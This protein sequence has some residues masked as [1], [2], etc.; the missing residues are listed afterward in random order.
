MTVPDPAAWPDGSR[1]PAC[2]APLERVHRHLLDRWISVFRSVH[3]YRCTAAACGWEGVLGRDAAG[4][5]PPRRWPV[6]VL[7]FVAGAALA[8]VAAQGLRQAL[9]T[10]PANDRSQ[11]ALGQGVETQSRA[12]A[13]GIDFAGA[14]L[15]AT[16]PRVRNNPSPLQLR[17]SCA[18]GVPGANPYRGTVTQALA[19]ARLPREVVRQIADMAER[20]AVLD[21]VQITRLG[22]R[23][24]NGQR[25]YGSRITAMAFGDTLCFNTRVNFPDGHVEHAAL[26]EAADASGKTYT[27]MVPYVCDNVSVLGA[28]EEIV[29]T[30]GVPSPASGALAVLGL[31]L[32]AALH[33]RRAGPGGRR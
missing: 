12:T 2:G 24:V 5:L 28:R 8:L 19:S 11:G 33:R 3:R 1:C 17:H 14:A 29:V 9:R 21:Q 23:S 27:V 13:P 6:A 7:A 31:G 32:M 20:G 16:D 22:I 25:D 15:P 4:L 26:Y 10:A 30:N 18:W